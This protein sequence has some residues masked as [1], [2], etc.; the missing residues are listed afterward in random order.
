MIGRTDTPL[1]TEAALRLR[2]SSFVI[3]AKRLSRL[4]KESVSNNNGAVVDT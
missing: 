4:R 3:E 2:K 1:V